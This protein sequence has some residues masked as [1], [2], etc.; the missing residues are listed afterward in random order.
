M[1]AHPVFFVCWM[2]AFAS[3]FFSS[4]FLLLVLSLLTREFVFVG[5]FVFLNFR[6]CSPVLVCIH[7]CLSAVFVRV[8]PCLPLFVCAHLCLLRVPLPFACVRSC[9]ALR[10]LFLV[11]LNAF[12]LGFLTLLVLCFSVLVRVVVCVCVCVCSCHLV[13]APLCSAVFVS[14]RLCTCV[15]LFL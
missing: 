12:V 2:C 6:L 7:L 10:L 15:C 5:C 1:E 8:L 3:F 9:L 11:S 14:G 4:F 13:S